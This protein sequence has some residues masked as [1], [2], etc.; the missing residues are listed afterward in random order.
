MRIGP[1]AGVALC[2]F[3]V[4]M[5]GGTLAS[6]TFDVNANGWG[7]FSFAVLGN[8][9]PNFGAAFGGASAVTYNATGGNPGGYISAADT[10][11]GWQYFQAGS[12]FT[13][14]FSAAY[15]GAVTFDLIR[16]D[17][18]STSVISPAGPILAITD[19]TT[20]LV[21]SG[22]EPTPVNGSWTN[23]SISL[24]AG[25]WT[26][27]DPT[28]AAATAG[29]LTTVLSSLSGLYILGDFTS[30]AP[31]TSNADAFG[32]DNV[33]I[34]SDPEPA[35]GMLMGGALAAAALARK[36]RRA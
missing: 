16:L 23:Y 33:S 9:Y 31:A 17:L 25:S 10:D 12:A 14:D 15:G 32:L 30:G 24:L 29:Q 28:G 26:V 35:T 1:I 7:T 19:G 34:V 20:V 21:Y 18:F 6:D 3:A 36:L 22:S 13:G 27:G 8:G 2:A 4:G 5:S 11:N